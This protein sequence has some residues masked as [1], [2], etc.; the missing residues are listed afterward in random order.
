MDIEYSGPVQIHIVQNCTNYM[1]L[2]RYL[3]LQFFQ[4]HIACKLQVNL[5]RHVSILVDIQNKNCYLLLKH[6]CRQHIFD[7]QQILQKMPF[8]PC[9][10]DSK[11]QVDLIRHV[12]ILVDI[13]N[14]NCCLLLKHICRQ[15]IF[16]KQQILRNQLFLCRNQGNLFE[17]LNFGTVPRYSSCNQQHLQL[18]LGYTED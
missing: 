17:L 15:H 7:R 10:I 9:H 12:S 11:M 8:L 18:C 14:K 16:D 13:Q 5:I 6:I 4:F 1:M 2:N 3:I